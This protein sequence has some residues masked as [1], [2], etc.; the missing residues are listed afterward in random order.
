[1]SFKRHLENRK[2]QKYENPIFN[3]KLIQKISDLSEKGLTALVKAARVE[4]KKICMAAGK[5]IL[6]ILDDVKT[7]KFLTRL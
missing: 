1:M 7:D 2:N 4:T 6:K 3:E 5:Y